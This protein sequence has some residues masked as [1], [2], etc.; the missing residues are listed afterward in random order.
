MEVTLESPHNR[1]PNSQMAQTNISPP[2]QIVPELA[3][4]EQS[5]PDQPPSSNLPETDLTS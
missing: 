5:A 3:V 1:A 4:H 2:E